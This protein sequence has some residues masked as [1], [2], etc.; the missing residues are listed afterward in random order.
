[1]GRSEISQ[2]QGTVTR[3]LKFAGIGLHS[4]KI[5]QL[6]ISPAPPNSGI[7]MIRSDLK[8]VE[9][10][11]A[12]PSNVISTVL[13]TTIGNHQYSIATIE[14]LMAAFAGL[15]IDNAFV[16]V[17]A[18]EIPILDGSAAPFVDK[19]Y[20]VGVQIQNIKRE[21]WAI[22][23][24]IKVENDDQYMI[25]EPLC[26]DD[27]QQLKA[28]TSLEFNC[29]I[30]F[31]NSGIIG[32]QAISMHFNHRNFMDICEARTFCHV[33]DINRMRSQGLALGGSLDNA[34]VVDD[35][36]VVNN[37]GLRFSD[38]F[39]RHKLLDCIGD[40]ALLGG[41]LSGR[42]HVHK[43]GHTLHN[44]FTKKVLDHLNIDLGDAIG[45]GGVERGFGRGDLFGL[46]AKA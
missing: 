17:S 3:T 41:R 1:M 13:S 15:G 42:I 12:H 45:A 22:S 34:V 28:E 31:N 20:E 32:Q 43:A 27:T 16:K 5:V 7:M 29:S 40:L 23:E 21:V 10:I 33:N 35:L 46:A 25:F 36:K 37:D 38:E 18:N 2:F 44:L 39:V 26:I 19:L 6:E 8:G 30:D 4:G 9:P 24:P 14:H 11:L